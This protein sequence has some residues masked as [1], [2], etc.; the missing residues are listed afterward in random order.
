MIIIEHHHN[1]PKSDRGSYVVGATISSQTSG[2]SL[3]GAEEDLRCGPIGSKVIGGLPNVPKRRGK[4]D[5]KESDRLEQVRSKIDVMLQAREDWDDQFVEHAHLDPRG[6]RTD[7]F[8][9]TYS[10]HM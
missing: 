5:T 6:T 1:L 10:V 8:P 9:T 3:S 7:S 4:G 2:I